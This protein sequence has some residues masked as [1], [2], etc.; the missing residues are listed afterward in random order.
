MGAK[1]C[2]LKTVTTCTTIDISSPLR[3]SDITAS[4]LGL[5]FGNTSHDVNES[6]PSIQPFRALESIAMNKTYTGPVD[7]CH[8]AERVQEDL[9][10]AARGGDLKRAVMA[11]TK[12]SSIHAKTL[13]G[14]TPLM[15]AAS[16]KGPD[17]LA[18]VQFCVEAKTNIEAKDTCGWT[19]LLHACR[20]S[21]V[22][23]VDYL[24]TQKASTKARTSDG[25][26]LV[27]LAIMDGA[28]G[29]AISLI[30]QKMPIDKKDERG[31]PALFYACDEDRYDLV[32]W[33]LRKQAN[34]KDRAKDG[35]SALMVSAEQNKVRI[36][37]FLVKKCVSVNS[38]NSSGFTALML[39]LNARR[40]EFSEW[41]LTLDTVDVF[42]KNY[43]GSDALE[44][45]VRHG[46]I[47][48]KNR[49][50][51]KARSSDGTLEDGVQ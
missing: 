49:I 10:Q 37:K 26:S 4:T 45:C 23:I 20:N 50:E 31:W 13:R 33:L 29:L 48:L 7:Q 41:L 19:A 32:K 51:A 12:G 46:L 47:A 22:E 38:R 39:S 1:S 18:L 3:D 40:H 42:L 27:M 8:D 44:I 2:S 16:S 6:L 34:V 35:M 5:L 28:D 9:F 11:I 24:L 30:N 14:Q 21:Q 15:L 36:G 43:E 17:A 25:R